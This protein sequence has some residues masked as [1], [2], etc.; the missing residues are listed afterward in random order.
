MANWIDVI[1][2]IA[3]AF[4]VYNS[5]TRGVMRSLLDVFVVLLSIFASGMIF[6][7]L[8]NS[9]MPFLNSTDKVVYVIS[10]IVFWI[11]AY[12][13]LD[14]VAGA[15][16]KIMKVTFMNPIESLGGALLGLIKGILIVGL[17]IQIT[18]LLPIAASNTDLINISLSKRLTLPTL[19]KSYS[20]LFG[21][22]PK[23]DLFIQEKVVPAVPTK[24]K[25]PSPKL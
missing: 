8:S 17:I 10:F 25:A 16:H 6:K 24:E 5:S 2:V 19:R 7:M 15:I 13:I 12:V 18:L 4:F 9:I 14:L 1:A 20:S 22:F 21:M 23:I 3:I 11:I